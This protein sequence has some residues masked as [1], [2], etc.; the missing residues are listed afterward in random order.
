MPRLWEVLPPAMGTML[1]PN[2]IGLWNA[3]NDMVWHRP[4]PL[5][6]RSFKL[7]FSS[8]GQKN[9]RYHQLARIEDNNFEGIKIR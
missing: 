1:N 7:Q 4:H 9:L 6:M 2:T 8:I 3:P 5:F